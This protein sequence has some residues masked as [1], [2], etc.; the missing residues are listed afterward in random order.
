MLL[1]WRGWRWE[2]NFQ[3]G[4]WDFTDALMGGLNWKKYE[5]LIKQFKKWQRV[6]F[7]THCLTFPSK[8][9]F[10]C[11]LHKEG[12]G[13][14]ETDLSTMA[15]VRKHS[16]KKIISE[17]SRNW[18]YIFS[19]LVLT[20][21]FQLFQWH[22]SVGRARFSQG[23]DISTMHGQCVSIQ[24]KNRSKKC[25]IHFFLTFLSW[26]LIVSVA[27]SSATAAALPNFLWGMRYSPWSGRCF[28]F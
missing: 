26:P 9:Y 12:G 15:S 5:L 8:M 1:A 24:L 17:Q 21:P 14:L 7:S 25:D 13:D 23:A 27:S 16:I 10:Y 22:G 2:F 20:P 3:S 11:C 4:G 28:S 19:H 6:F 18:R